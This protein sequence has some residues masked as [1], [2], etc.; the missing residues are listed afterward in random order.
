MALRNVLSQIVSSR[1]RPANV[2]LPQ[3]R[4]I[5]RHKVFRRFQQS[6]KGK[7]RTNLVIKHVVVVVV[8]ENPE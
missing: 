6:Q 2:L 5:D 7:E 3:G 1:F 8:V 4:M